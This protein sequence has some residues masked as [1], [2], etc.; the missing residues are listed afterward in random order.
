MRIAARSL[1]LDLA[2]GG[3]STESSVKYDPAMVERLL[4]TAGFARVHTATDHAARFAV[5]VARAR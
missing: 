5:H 1:D 2:D 4:A 3:A